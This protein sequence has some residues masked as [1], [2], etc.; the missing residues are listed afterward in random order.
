MQ[1]RQNNNLLDCTPLLLE[2]VCA[3]GT[4]CYHDIH[5]L[6]ESDTGLPIPADACPLNCV[7][8]NLVIIGVDIPVPPGGFPPRRVGDCIIFTVQYRVRVFFEF[9][10]AA[11][12]STEVGTA[13]GTFERE[14]AV[15]VE[16]INGGCITCN[17][18]EIDICIRRLNL[19]CIRALVVPR[20]AGFPGTFPPFALEITVEKE[21]FALESGRSIVCVPACVLECIELPFPVLPG[22]CVPF[23]R[24]GRCP[25]FCQES[26]LE[27]GNC[28]QCPPPQISSTTTT[29]TSTST[30]TTTTTTSATTT[31]TTTSA[32][33]TTTTTSATTTTTTTT[34]QG[35]CECFTTGG[36]T[37]TVTS[38]QAI[39]QNAIGEGVSLGYNACPGCNFNAN[40][41]FSISINGEQQTLLGPDLISLDCDANNTTATIVG[42][43]DYGTGGNRQDVTFTLIVNEVN[44]S[45]SLVIRN[46]ANTVLFSTGGFIALTGQGVMVRD[47]PLGPSS[48][49]CPD[50]PDL[51][52]P[53]C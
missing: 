49:E 22:E 10:D 15:P 42:S 47:C 45:F 8:N 19:D 27:P 11:T 7:V 37:G 24:P 36:G 31:T 38:N 48:F 44:N 14:L 52:C 51:D 4:K 43:G 32:T 29:T 6:F 34:A 17:P 20:P 35:F 21:F 3:T 13:E 28:A 40:V 23:E 30:T 26:D 9:F 5:Y 1:T 18:Q 50:C 53:E 16:D 2:K 25:S 33:T 39:P 12:N 41:T 46:L